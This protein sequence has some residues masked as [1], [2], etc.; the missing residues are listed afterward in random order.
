[1]ICSTFPKS[2]AGI[3]SGDFCFVHRADGR[4]ALFVYLFARPKTRS[5]F[6]GALATTVL[7]HARIEGIP[8]KLTLGDHALLHIKCFRE[9][10]TP[11]AGNVLDRIDAAVLDAK[12]A[13]AF[14]HVVGSSTL[15][16]G[17]RTIVARANAVPA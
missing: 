2:N 6:F 5:S 8:A 10:N 14:S 9:N 11:V 7:P 17:Y 12:K 16:W 1:V 13:E 4:V 15:V 3:R